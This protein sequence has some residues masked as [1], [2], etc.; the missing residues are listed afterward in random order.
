MIIT[1]LEQAMSFIIERFGE[2]YETMAMAL[3]RLFF[4]KYR[5]PWRLEETAKDMMG[6][7]RLYVVC[8]VDL[9]IPFDGTSRVI[10]IIRTPL[11]ST[12]TFDRQSAELDPSQ[13]S[14]LPASEVTT[15][16]AGN[17]LLIVIRCAA[18]TEH[19]VAS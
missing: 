15:R 10:M 9:N 4:K 18:R 17:N 6:C 7:W 3:G 2:C 19:R 14:T 8:I 5:Y 12:S 16:Q 13:S 11:I 1:P